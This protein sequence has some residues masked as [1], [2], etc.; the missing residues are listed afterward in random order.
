LYNH[1]VT[2]DNPKNS[3]VLPSPETPVP[4]L[5]RVLIAPF[6]GVI[7]FYRRFISPLFPPTCRFEPS[8]S[9][10]A[11]LALRKYGLVKGLAKAVWRVLRCNPWGGSGYDPP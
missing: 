2:A 3:S 7:W 4:T 6:V 11:V 1:A 5:R 8:C 9:E 10:Y